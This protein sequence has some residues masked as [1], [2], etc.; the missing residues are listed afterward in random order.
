MRYL[1]GNK[2]FCHHVDI[3]VAINFS[4][5]WKV[6]IVFTVLCPY[7]YISPPYQDK[8][9]EMLDRDQAHFGI[10]S[11][12]ENEIDLNLGIII[13][14]GFQVQCEQC[15]YFLAMLFSCYHVPTI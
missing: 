10:S 2:S 13:R 3:K 5:S 9:L 12:E 7:I 6:S 4:S 15:V 14:V 1:L 8:V 11:Y